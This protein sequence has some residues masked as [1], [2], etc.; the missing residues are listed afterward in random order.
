M[1]ISGSSAQRTRKQDLEVIQSNKSRIGLASYTDTHQILF[2]TY[3]ISS[4]GY[5]NTLETD[6]IILH[7]SECPPHVQNEEPG[8]EAVLLDNGRD[9]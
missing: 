4:S 8:P 3:Y 2:K 6:F 1:R 7:D 5:E 9:Y